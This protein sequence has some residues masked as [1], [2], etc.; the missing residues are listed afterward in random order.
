MGVGDE[1]MATAQARRLQAL[2]PRP[3][4]V[5]AKD[6]I[7]ARWHVIWDGNPRL[8]KPEQLAGCEVQWLD[9]CSGRRPYIDYANTTREKW[10]W[11]ADEPR[12]PGEIY[13]SGA[14]RQAFAHLRDCVLI[15]PNLKPGA[16][17]TK[18]WGWDRWQELVLA[19]R[20]VPWIQIGETRQKVLQGVGFVTTRTVREAAAVVANVRSAVLPEGGLHHAAAALGTPAVVVFGGY[21]APAVTG[22]ATQVSLFMES[23]EYPLG[24]GWRRPCRHCDAAMAS[25][26]VERVVHE[27][28]GLLRKAA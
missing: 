7:N 19:R 28:D 24:C 9:N 23:D 12:E 18:Q 8:I 22:Y 25:I 1:I 2:D 3:V 16:P 10:C 15:E 14:E 17:L 11:R 26:T 27:L 13:L 6:R 5:R 21:I 20:D 4:A